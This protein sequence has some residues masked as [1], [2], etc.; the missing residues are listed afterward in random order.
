MAIKP[1]VQ[2]APN[3]TPADA[4]YPYGS[5][6]NE[7]VPGVFDGTPYNLTRAN[8][9]FGLQQALLSAAGIVPS[10]SADTVLV[11]QYRDALKVILG[12]AG[13]YQNDINYPVGG[14]ARGSDDFLYR[15]VAANGP[16]TSVVDPVTDGPFGTTWV[17]SGASRTLVFSSSQ[18]YNPPAGV[19]GLKF[20]AIGPGGGSGG[21]DGQGVGT[22]AISGPGGGGGTAIKKTNQIEAAYTLVVGAGGVKGASGANNGAT[23]GTTTVASVAVNLS[24]NGGGGG[25]GMTGTASLGFGTGFV[26]GGTASGGDLNYRGGDVP[27]ASVGSGQV[28]NRPPSGAST[29]GG[30]RSTGSNANGFNGVTPG[31][32]GGSCNATATSNNFSGGNGA[33]GEITIEE[34]Y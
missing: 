29:A 2:L 21:I 17:M 31:S 26:N 32:G 33:D 19:L 6:K 4:N 7:T 34:V 20:T 11:S 18:V 16:A 1:D 15:A 8:D 27:E 5:S 12:G 24:A 3:V 23:G 14:Y 13:V 28:V 22:A 25:G 10:G 30:A 9:I